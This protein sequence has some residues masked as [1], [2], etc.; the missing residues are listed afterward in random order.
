MLIKINFHDKTCFYLPHIQIK[1][2]LNYFIKKYQASPDEIRYQKVPL[3]LFR[4]EMSLEEFIKEVE[5][6]YSH[7][8]TTQIIQIRNDLIRP[9]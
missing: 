9:N 3:S 2:V 7:R 5:D 8:T 4:R 1:D 6:K